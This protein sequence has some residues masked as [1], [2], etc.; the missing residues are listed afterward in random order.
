MPVSLSIDHRF[1]SGKQTAYIQA[2]GPQHRQKLG[3]GSRA[4]IAKSSIFHH[5]FS[6][7]LKQFSQLFIF[8]ALRFRFPSMGMPSYQ[9]FEQIFLY[10]QSK[11]LL[12]HLSLKSSVLKNIASGC[13][14]SASSLWLSLS[15]RTFEL[16]QWF[17]PA[18]SF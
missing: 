16:C 18:I 13:C 5:M 3:M 14:L 11:F 2:L 4:F 17:L 6:H 7:C 10:Q 9:L 15:K 8:R 12:V 1:Q